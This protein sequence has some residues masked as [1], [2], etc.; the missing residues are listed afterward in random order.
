MAGQV[1][2][3]QRENSFRDKF[4]RYIARDRT[5]ADLRRKALTAV[6]A[7]MARVV[8]AVI[9]GGTEYRPFFEGGGAKWKN[10]SQQCREGAIA[11]L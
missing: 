5:N 6:T 11:T 9:K 2:I 8:H 4:E 7:K 10:P 3:R 1:A